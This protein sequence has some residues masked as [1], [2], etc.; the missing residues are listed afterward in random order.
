L[1]EA[2]RDL[3]DLESTTLGFTSRDPKRRMP[4]VSR[5]VPPA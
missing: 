5:S 4:A 2:M 3:E 1:R